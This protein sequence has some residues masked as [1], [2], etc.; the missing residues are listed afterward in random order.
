MREG[1]KGTRVADAGAA[2]DVGLEWVEASLFVA[3]GAGDE[4]QG[5]LA[6][7]THSLQGSSRLV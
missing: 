6:H 4:G 7:V 3:D 5:G 1:G 2:H